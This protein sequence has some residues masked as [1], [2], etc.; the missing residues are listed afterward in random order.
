MQEEREPH[1]I[2]LKRPL[3][4]ATARS[5]QNLAIRG[6][7]ESKKIMFAGDSEIFCHS[8]RNLANL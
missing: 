8:P 2:F 6:A 1:E 3:Q 5:P 7:E 4:P